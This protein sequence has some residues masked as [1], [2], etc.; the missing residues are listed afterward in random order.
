[1]NR[2]EKRVLKYNVILVYSSHSRFNAVRRF[3]EEAKTP[4]NYIWDQLYGRELDCVLPQFPLE[5]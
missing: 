2:L 4:G 1:M 3:E 5:V